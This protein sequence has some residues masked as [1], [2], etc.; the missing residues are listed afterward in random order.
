MLRV[1]NQVLL[2]LGISALSS[3]PSTYAASF[4]SMSSVLAIFSEVRSQRS[5]VRKYS[6]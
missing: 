1:V 6:R 4:A 5:E 3:S 2:D